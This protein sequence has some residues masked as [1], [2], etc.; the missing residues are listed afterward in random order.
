MGLVRASLRNPY[1]VIV[2]ALAVLVLGCVSYSRMPLDILPEFKTPA[3]QILTLYPGMPTEIVERDMTNR[4]ER[5][6]SQAMGVAWQESRSMVGV[7]VV[8]DFFRDD[9]DPNT[10]MSQVSALALADLYYLP[11][12][13]IP[14]M[15]MMYDPTASQ[16]LCLVACSSDTL[17]ETEVYDFAYFQMRNM[18]S[19]TP[20]VIAPAVFGGKLRRVY[21]Y[22]DKDKVQARNM[23][24][25]D[26]V[27]ALTRFNLMIPTGNAKL[28]DLDYSINMESFVPTVGDLNDIPVKVE[29]DELNGD[30]RP[31]L[32]KDVG[33]AEDTSAI[34][35]NVVRIARAPETKDGKQ[36]ADGKTWPGKRQVYIP[37]YRQPGSNS[38]QVVE[39]TKDTLKTAILPRAPEGFQ[40][41]VVGDQTVFIRQA[42]A[43]LQKEGV[44]GALLASLMILLFLGSLRSTLAILL[45]IPLSVLAA[46]IGLYYTNNTINSMTL[47]GLALALGRLV[48]DSIVVL[49]NTHR[50]LRMGKPPREAALEGA[51]EVSMPVFVATLTTIV[52]FFPVT[53]LYGM[54]KYLFTPLALAVAFSMIASYFVAMTL[55]PAYCARFLRLDPKDKLT[56]APQH[57]DAASNTPDQ[58]DPSA[59]RG[60]YGALQAGYLRVLNRSLRAKPSVLALA[61]G[62][63]VASLLLFPAIGREL[64]PPLDAGQ[65]LVQV[66]MPSGTRIERTETTLARVEEALQ[67]VIPERDREM[68]VTNIGVLYD[69]PAGYTPNAG[70]HDGFILTQLTMHGR[71][72]TSYE[73]ADRLRAALPKKFPGVQFSFNTGGIVTAA[74]NFGLPSPIDVQIEGK[75]LEKLYEISR[76]VKSVIQKEV[77]GAV[78]V[79]VQ[80]ELDY[81]QI[82]IKV[83]RVKAALVGL[84]QEEVVK[85]VVT[86]LNSS[87]NFD[88]A[89]WLDDKTG[90]HYFVG[91]TYREDDIESLATLENIPITSGAQSQPV[92]LKNLATF[93]RATVPTEVAHNRI[94]RVMDVYANVTR[95]ATGD[96][97]AEIQRVVER[98]RQTDPAQDPLHVDVPDGYFVHYR[99]EYASLKE[100]FRSLG[101]AFVLSSLLV[102][103]IMVAQFQS[104]VDPFI[105]MFAVPLGL[106]GVA[107]LLFATGTTLN[108]ESFMGVI[109][110]VGIAVSNS[111]LLVE[112]SNRL[113]GRG[114]SARE[115]AVQAAG[116]RLRPILMTAL[117]AIIALVP[118]ALAEGEAAMPLARAVIGGLLAS[119]VLSLLVV[120]VL[121][122]LIKGRTPSPVVE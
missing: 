62:L 10:A 118:M 63:F 34:Q 102:Y 111:V 77:A 61:G 4:L 104:F 115:A 33:K 23:S 31:V 36:S 27:N 81:P 52:V 11:P 18:L 80:Q 86:A 39:G 1:A 44:L 88:P 73:L 47:G 82:N 19:G 70:P 108:V 107:A 21:V 53:F 87:I 78:D 29:R 12:G 114:L 91:A 16:P 22:L 72:T 93:A 26:V 101:F 65:I 109:F 6:T 95:R 112:F 59:E 48:D 116:I 14:P 60:W 69:W 32:V 68:L 20:G 51:T 92:L 97:A 58:G 113:R 110:M 28:G 75:S 122:E 105:V 117:A 121:Y 94:R 37:I 84:T 71:K 83:D 119:T 64:F 120:P 43:A 17:D 24:P 35:T 89:F 106:I 3:V 7:S 9:I 54:G 50:H 42:I 98:H 13:T 74:L 25:L 41:K 5:W 55:V 103:L 56:A 76:Q 96:V 67:K 40:T 8:R 66:R 99:G 85:N 15:T 57:D 45:S 100:S 2:G 90:N 46:F 79:R 38:L 30:L 49:E